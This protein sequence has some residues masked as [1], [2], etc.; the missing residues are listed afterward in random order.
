MIIY[1]L[2][3]FARFA[4]SENIEDKSL[5]EAVVR[6][7]RGLVD[8]NLGSGLIKQRVSRKGQGRS[9]GYRVIIAFQ[10]GKFA[11][12]MFGFAKSAQSN[13]DEQQLKA[14]RNIAE[15]WL[16]ADGDAFRAALEQGKIMEIKND[17]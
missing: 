11:L 10:V 13:L 7:G 4:K 5:I 12:F 9:S 2:K 16:L 15:D 17:T 1:K 6:V 8:A 14:L 3:S